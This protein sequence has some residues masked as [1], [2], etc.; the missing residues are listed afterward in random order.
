[1]KTLPLTVFPS[2]QKHRVWIL[3]D[4]TSII[5]RYWEFLW[6]NFPK[7]VEPLLPQFQDVLPC[8]IIGRK[9]VKKLNS[10]DVNERKFLIIQGESKVYEHFQNPVS[11]IFYNEYKTQR[12][13]V[14]FSS[15]RTVDTNIALLCNSCQQCGTQS[16]GDLFFTPTHSN[17]SGGHT[18]NRSFDPR[19]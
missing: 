14:C 5:G 19:F 13:I 1:M 2:G 11:S 9:N 6:L 12:N 7:L 18:E 17:M 10:S 15:T 3:Q 8:F 16:T 4:F